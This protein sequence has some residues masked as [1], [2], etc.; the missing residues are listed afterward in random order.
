MICPNCLSNN[1]RSA[2]TCKKCGCPLDDIKSDTEY[3][4][5]KPKN[6]SKPQVDENMRYTVKK[7]V[8]SDIDYDVPYVD[9]SFSQ[10]TMNMAPIRN[11]P[12]NRKKST[13]GAGKNGIYSSKTIRSSKKKRTFT[14]IFTLILWLLVLGGLIAGGIIGVNYLINLFNN[15]IPPIETPAPSKLPASKPDIYVLTDDNGQQYVNCKFYGNDSDTVHIL[16]GQKNERLSFENGVAELNLYLSDILSSNANIGSEKVPVAITATYRYSDGIEVPVEV[17]TVEFTVPVTEITLLTSQSKAIEVFKDTYTLV[18][19]IPK[20]S[21]LYIND[22]ISNDKADSSGRVEYTVI[23]PLG[24]S[25]N[26]NVRVQAPYH[27]ATEAMFTIYR[28]T[29]NT[30]FT[31]AGSNPKTTNTDTIKITG[32]IKNGTTV[33]CDAK[34][35]VSDYT[36]NPGTGVFSMN[37]TLPSHG[38]HDILF[39]ATDSS[40]KV[41]KLTHTVNYLPDEDQYTR[42]AWAYD[43]SVAKNP[44]QYMYKSFLFKDVK[45]QE[46]VLAEQKTFLIN[47]GS[48][49]K[50][51]YI[52][53]QYSGP[54]S[55][56]TTTTYRIF[57][58]VI[59]TKDGITLV[60]ARFIYNW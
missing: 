13:P 60:A 38:V 31:L 33:S 23:V 49:E 46:F 3:A 21:N 42:R 15:S 50:P 30:K 37:V 55:L 32:T 44:T 11:N 47:M 9:N 27:K 26:V 59:G 48:E 39:T 10:D 8:A 20:G 17:P 34:Y 19:A 4:Q 7:V 14:M 28:Q 51:E 54:L 58:D 45:I 43:S 25:V 24:E 29:L 16:V 22:V 52:Y 35:K 18:F 57:G 1:S 5:Y 6:Q 2:M 56:N 53:V 36:F 40:G 41:A 12:T